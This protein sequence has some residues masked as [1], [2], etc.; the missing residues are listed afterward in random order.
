MASPTNDAGGPISEPLIDR[1][2]RIALPL[3]MMLTF[4]PLINAY[5]LG[6]LQS[7]LFAGFMLMVW[8]WMDKR[9]I[10]A[11]LLAGLLTCGKPQFGLLLIWAATRRKWS[12]CG[13]FL[14]VAL[15]AGLISLAL[16]GITENLDYLNVLAFLS[17]HGESWWWNQ[18]VNGLL[19]RAIYLH[20]AFTWNQ[21]FL[22]PYNPV[23][24]YGTILSSL[25]LIAGGLFVPARFRGGIADLLLASLTCTIASP[26]AWIHHYTILLPVFAAMFAWSATVRPLGRW[27]LPVLCISYTLVGTYQGAFW[28][29]A[30]SRFNYIQSYPLAGVLIALFV[31]YVWVIRGEPG[32]AF[33]PSGRQIPAAHAGAE[34]APLPQPL[35]V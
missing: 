15:A 34:R 30:L 19:N 13:A 3:L 14:V 35:A 5:R 26:V 9:Y 4:Y 12:F 11:G 7:W 8:L 28:K 16:F 31:L 27:T 18:S 22:P 20:G 1:I 33:E 23:V 2:G 10:A 24:Y 17:R 29:L 32:G 25:A 21:H 6:Q